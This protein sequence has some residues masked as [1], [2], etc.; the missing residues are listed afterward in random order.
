M[1]L[2]DYHG[3]SDKGAVEMNRKEVQAWF[4]L[5]D[6]EL[7]SFEQAGLY[8]HPKAENG[9]MEYDD[10]D[11]KR[12]SLLVTLTQIGMNMEDIKTYIGYER[13]DID[14]KSKKVLLLKKH[15]QALLEKL[16]DQQ[17]CIDCLDMLLYD[18]QGCCCKR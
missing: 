5:R 7:Q 6:E 18:L 9:L 16:H 1:F 8:D 15:R 4:P 12:L 3:S 17:K 11:I 10:K 14:Q 2:F 13:C